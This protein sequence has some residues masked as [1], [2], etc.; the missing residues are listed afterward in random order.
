[1]TVYPAQK[2]GEA[3]SNGTPS[4]ISAQPEAQAIISSELPPPTFIQL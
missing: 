2:I 4:G 1:M 3:I